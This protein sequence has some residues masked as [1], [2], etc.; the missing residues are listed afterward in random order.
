MTGIDYDN[1]FNTADK[2]SL[3]LHSCC[4]PCSSYCLV[5]MRRWFDITCLY[6]NPNI[7][8]REEYEKRS[9]ELIRL[10]DMLNND[11]VYVKDGELVVSSKEPGVEYS[12]IKVITCDFSPQ[13]FVEAVEK[14]NLQ[15]CPERGERCNM[16]FAM[17][18]NETYKVAKE[19]EFDYFATT[20]TL[21]PLK[22]AELINKIGESIGNSNGDR[23]S[24]IEQTTGDRPQ[25]QG[26]QTPLSGHGSKGDRPRFPQWLYTDFKKK[27]GYKIS[28]EL[29][30]RYDLYRQNY[31]GCEYSKKDR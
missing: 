26:G 12:P 13:G 11:P 20:L 2:P 31:C 14:G 22:N 3:L 17:R 7:T 6:Y 25:G 21:S 16:C 1:Y 29:S 19:K 18:L 23:P 5:Y 15:D 4:A 30:K 10:A 24:E 27:N 8:N 28:I 9:D